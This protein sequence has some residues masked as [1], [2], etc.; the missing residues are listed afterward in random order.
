[1]AGQGDIVVLDV[2]KTLSKLS[3]W[4]RAG[5]LLE[6]V[7]RLNARVAVDGVAVLDVAGI[8]DWVQETLK[9]FAAAGPVSA[10]IPVGHGAAVAAI[11]DAKLAFAPLDYEQPMPPGVL[12]DYR[13]GRDRFADTGSPALPL[14]LNFGAQLHWLATKTNGAT[15]LPWAQ[16]WSWFLSGAAT[17]EVTSLG[18]HSD[19][20]NPGACDYSAVAK[21]RGWAA[22]FAPLAKAGDAIGMLKPEFGLGENVRV[23]CGIHDSNAALIAARGFPEIA[24]KE[25]TV[26]STG[27]WFVAMRSPAEPIDLTALPEARDCL[28]NVDAFGQPVASARFMGGREIELL[29]DRIDLP[30]DQHAML[31]SLPDVLGSG[32]MILPGFAPGCG[33]FPDNAGEWINKPEDL[34]QQRATIALYVALLA[35]ISLDL[36]GAKDRL[37]IEGRFAQC[38]LFVRALATLQPDMRVFAASEEAD[39][40]LGAVRLID[41]AIRPA[42]KLVL[43]TPLNED[44]SQY[45]AQWRERGG[46]A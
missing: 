26:L 1:M 2:G 29:G 24:G 20:W 15:L 12:A 7:S 39:V 25:A 36:I 44:L 22:Q 30:E 11:R 14:G 40:S 13:A 23:H 31:R 5:L 43:A 21:R 10:I 45:K 8:G 35:D 42:A 46:Q 32:A 9:S 18:C 34:N 28:V 41:P 3:R 16:Y 6:K 19:L 27:T 38:D 33:P 17:S 37:L 4:S